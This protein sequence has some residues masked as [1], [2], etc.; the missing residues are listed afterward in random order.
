MELGIDLQYLLFLQNLRLATGGIFDEFFN[1]MSKVAVDVLPFLPFLIFL[2][3]DKKWG[4]RFLTVHRGA[5]LLN[6]V[7]KLT[8]CA[9]RP[10]IRS[11]LIEPAGDSKVAATGYSF[12]SGHT[13]AASSLYGSIVENQWN[14]RRWLAILCIICILLTGFSRNFLGVHTPQ[15]VFVGLTEG[16]VMILIVRKVSQ[17]V[18]DNDK[19]IDI[20][21]LVGILVVVAVL[22]YIQVKPYPMDYVDGKLLVDPKKMMNDC[23]KACGAFLGLLLGS[24]VERH[25]IHYE[26]PF[27]YKNLP[28]LASVSVTLLFIWKTYF[29]KATIIPLLGGHWGNLV[30]RFGMTFIGLTLIPYLIMKCAR[31]SQ[32][33][34][35][36]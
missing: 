2:C 19:T 34:T 6:G 3:V 35:A 32:Q 5:E 20:L 16:I 25:Y 22:I 4:Y 18:G 13:V 33:Q 23:F 14:K 8:V 17:V 21:T 36:A 9:Y 30:S 24:Y 26:I 10:W 11:N 7:V 1:G 27:G 31:E 12:P 15:D 28:I 29:E